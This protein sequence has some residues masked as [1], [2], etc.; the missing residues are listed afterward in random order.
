ML[1]LC[2]GNGLFSEACTVYTQV[3]LQ[4]SAS[5]EVESQTLSNADTKQEARWDS[6]RRRNK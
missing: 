2:T 4:S 6:E 5:L 1:G 3:E